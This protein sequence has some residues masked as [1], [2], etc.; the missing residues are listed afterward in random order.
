VGL[1][2]GVA[3]L[4]VGHLLG[5][6]GNIF[7]RRYV[8]EQINWVHVGTEE[9]LYVCLV[10]VIAMLAGIVPALKAYR[11]PVATNLVA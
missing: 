7:F 11:T 1:I 8:G 4:V 10:V 2:G 6:V 9:I 5:A 3:G